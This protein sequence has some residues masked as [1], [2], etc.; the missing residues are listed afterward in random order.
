MRMILCAVEDC[1]DAIDQ[2]IAEYDRKVREA[3]GALD[4]LK[5]QKAEAQKQ[6]EQ[7]EKDAQ[8]KQDQFDDWKKL[9]A[10]IEGKLAAI[11]E[12]KTRIEKEDDQSNAASMYFLAIELQNTLHSIKL[13]ST[14]DFKD[15][16]M[17]SWEELGQAK[18]VARQKKSALDAAAA[19]VDEAQK[20]LDDLKSKRQE[21]ILQQIAV[22]NKSAK[23]KDQV[24]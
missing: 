8:K 15:K 17:A 11:Q 19:K 24:R 1:K 10:E 6:Y 7:A 12:L 23:K 3:E 16:L 20:A 13:L 4:Q 5:T 14:R 2:K 9:Q 22:H 21:T 18:E